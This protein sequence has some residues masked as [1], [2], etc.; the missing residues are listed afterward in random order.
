MQTGPKIRNFYRSAF[1]IK[2]GCCTLLCWVGMGTMGV[3]ILN[4]RSLGSKSSLQYMF[5]KGNPFTWCVRVS[6]KVVFYFLSPSKPSFK[7]FLAF[8][9]FGAIS[10]QQFTELETCKIE[11]IY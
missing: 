9:F 10:L 11:H 8:R 4:E 7:S 3:S 5:S 2:I 1:F 6:V